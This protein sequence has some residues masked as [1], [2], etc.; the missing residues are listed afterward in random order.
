MVIDAMVRVVRLGDGWEDNILS[1]PHFGVPF[2]VFEV[3]K[4]YII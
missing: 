2:N 1:P 3:G 4:H